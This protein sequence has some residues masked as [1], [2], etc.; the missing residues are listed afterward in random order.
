[1]PNNRFRFGQIVGI[2]VGVIIGSMAISVILGPRKQPSYYQP[3][4]N[5]Q[6]IQPVQQQGVF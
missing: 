4:M 1:M 6:Y 5:E 2:V 3:Y